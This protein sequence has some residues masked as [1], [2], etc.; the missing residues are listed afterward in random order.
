M[1]GIIDQTHAD[2]FLQAFAHSV[3]TLML[4]ICGL[5]ILLIVIVKESCINLSIDHYTQDTKKTVPT[6]EASWR[7]TILTIP[8]WN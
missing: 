3:V 2:N 1:L 8:F 5:Y 6:A 7:Y 4:A